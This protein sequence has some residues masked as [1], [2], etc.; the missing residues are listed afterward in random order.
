MSVRMIAERGRWLF[1]RVILPICLLLII[2]VALPYAASAKPNSP[3]NGTKT[4]QRTLVRGSA[5][6]E[7]A[8]GTTPGIAPAVGPETLDGH[9]ARIAFKTQA[10]LRDLVQR[11]DVWE[12]YPDE[13]YVVAYVT[14]RDMAWLE[15]QGLK[16]DLMGAANLIPSTIPDYP[17]YRT[18]E[19]LYV[20]L[21][22]WASQYPRLTELEVIGSSYE[23]RPLTVMHVANPA[24]TTAGLDP[25]RPVFFVMANVHGR[26]LITNELAMVFLEH[27]LTQYGVDADVTWLLDHHHIAVLVSG[28]P[29]GH[30]KNEPGQP[31]AYWRKNTNITYGPDC[32]QYGVDL[33]RNAGFQWG[34]ASDQPCD[35]LYQ[36]P[37]PVSERETQ[38]IQAF[39][40]LL[41]PDRRPND[42]TTP[43]P[44]DTMGV[45]ITLHSYSNLVLW[46]WGYTRNAQAPNHNQLAM[47]GRKLATYNDYD[48]RQASGLYPASGTNDDW[49]YGELGIAAYTFEIG[50]PAQGFYPSCNDYDVLT[51]PNLDALLYTAKVVRTPYI[52]AFGPDA[53]DVSV[54]QRADAAT[55]VFTVTAQ[56][57]D[58]ANG[59][60]IIA[61][62]EAYID[63]PPWDGG[64]AYPLASIDGGFGT[65]VEA[66]QGILVPTPTV[67]SGS[68]LYVRGQD[69]DGMW[70]PVSA[71]FIPPTY[72][73]TMSPR[74]LLV[75]EPGTTVVHTLVLTNTGTLSQ[76]F[77]LSTTGEAWTTTVVPT[78]T[79]LLP[80]AATPVTVAVRL[81][82]R[83]EIAPSD[84]TTLTVRSL[85]APNLVRAAVLETRAL[86][87]RMSLPLVVRHGP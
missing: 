27:L 83:E 87:A 60:R 49:A 1:R 77:M 86:W 4:S 32:S 36:G 11:L 47:L 9:L 76:T 56:I 69:I 34:G 6:D 62:A 35:I 24:T 14:S 54:E 19:E 42:T 17:C 43:A 23:D 82:P 18:I 39:M 10:T 2:I 64:V 40:Q 28:N 22:A 63:V 21:D 15:T 46:P 70:G 29:D 33:N 38:A 20:Q 51:Q 66:V 7:R 72:H 45:F 71:T 30:V 79:H 75:G 59:G 74:S 78:Q 61:A 44:D 55:Q 68:L 31:W 3:F 48:P 5:Y 73:Y 57:D 65:S 84:T 52:T 58:T 81:P 37:A 67:A 25:D 50:S 12:S 41:F 8:V 13:G 53:V 16:A 80:G 26:E 85:A